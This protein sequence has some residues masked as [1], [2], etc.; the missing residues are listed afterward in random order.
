[1]RLPLRA[2]PALPGRAARAAAAADPAPAPRTGPA[3]PAQ[4]D[5]GPVQALARAHA[6]ERAGEPGAALPGLVRAAARWPM[7]A[8]LHAAAAQ[9]ALDQGAAEA[10]Q[11][12]LRR[13]LYLEPDSVIGHYLDGVT[14]AQLG[15]HARARQAFEAAAALLA[16]LPAGLP[17]PGADGWLAGGLRACI[18]AWTERTS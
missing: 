9:L 17:V 11:R 18:H 7:S 4:P 8:P 2:S 10:A 13:L 15:R 6:L 12:H 1:V 14:Q 3:P 16:A 5:D